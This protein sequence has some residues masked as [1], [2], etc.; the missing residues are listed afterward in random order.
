MIRDDLTLSSMR[1]GATRD[2]D[3]EHPISSTST[4]A[5]SSARLRY[6]RIARSLAACDALIAVGALLVVHLLTREPGSIST[7]PLIALSIAPAAWVAAFLTF[8]LYDLKRLSGWSEFPRI[9]SATMVAVFLLVLGGLWSDRSLTRDS[10]AL[11]LIVALSLEL[12][13]RSFFRSF[14]RRLKHRGRLSLRTLVVGAN[15]EAHRIAR[16]LSDTAAGFLPLGFV[17]T[18]MDEA[19]GN[20]IPVVGGIEQIEETVRSYAAECVFVA[21]SSVSPEELLRITRICRRQDVELRISTSVSDVLISRLSIQ[22]IDGMPTLTIK[23]V[24]LSRTQAILKRSFDLVFASIALVLALPLMMLIALAIKLTSSG[25]VL[26]A[27]PR[28][29]KDGDVFVMHKFRTMVTDPARALEHK[30]IDLTRPFFKLQNDPRLTP[31]GRVLRSSSLDEFPQLWNV[32]KGDM[33]LV[34]P[35]PLPAEQVM[36]NHDF[37]SP[38]HDVRAGIT[39]LWQIS[40]RSALDSDEALRID[41]YYIENWSFGLDVHILIKT[42]GAVLARRG[43]W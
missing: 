4:T 34:G 40:G 28:V 36:A 5:G 21:S 3:G 33:S 15:G 43:A 22:P 23:P 30:V 18:A 41:R 6:R 16:L 20:S 25:P 9:V 24:R 37:L 42:I 12:L 27:Q 26:F 32:V 2:G 7:H 29:T 39:G 35:R 8:G 19:S 11:T 13:A 17:A 1:R 31:V 38:R 10:L 14:V